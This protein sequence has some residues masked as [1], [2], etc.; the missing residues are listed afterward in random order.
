M[1]GDTGVL[2]PAWPVSL[3]HHSLTFTRGWLLVI[4][5]RQPRPTPTRMSGA[6]SGWTH[7]TGELEG[8]TALSTSLSP[9]SSSFLHP[10]AKAFFLWSIQ[11]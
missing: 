6:G 3:C 5:S 2:L 8:A 4:C 11:P 10:L 7:S 1:W 9:T